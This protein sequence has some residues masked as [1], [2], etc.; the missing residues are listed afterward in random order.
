[1]ERLLLA[2]KRKKERRQLEDWLSKSFRI[3]LPDPEQPLQPE[4]DLAIIDGSTLRKLKPQVRA[5]RLAEEPVFL[6]FLLLTVRRGESMGAR[7][8]GNVVDDVILRPVSEKELK[9]R[10]ANLLR[11]RSWS[12]DLKREHDRVMKLAV[13]DD[14]SG[15][16]NTRYLH[17]YLDRFFDAAVTKPASLC[18]VFFDLDNFKHLVDAHGHLRGTKALREVAQAVHRV[19]DPDDRLVRYG[20]DEFIVLL[21][22]QTKEQARAKVKRM[23]QAISETLF[24]QKESVD[25]QLTASFGMACFPEDARDKEELLAEA[26]RCL[27]HSKAEGKDRITVLELEKAA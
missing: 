26:D 23:Q 12:L 5:R 20:G 17:R 9:A 7:Y 25:A 8:L 3:L 19:M 10:V 14:V 22:R 2:V 21:P 16:N 27:F 1:M 24:L 4:F 6:P 13:T 18:L 11:M 15:F